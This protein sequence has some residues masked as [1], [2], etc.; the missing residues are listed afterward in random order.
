MNHRRIVGEFD[1]RKTLCLTL[2]RRVRMR[3][4]LQEEN[5]ERQN[6]LRL[7]RYIERRSRTVIHAFRAIY[8]GTRSNI[9]RHLRVFKP[10]VVTDR[11]FR[12]CTRECIFRST[13]K[14]LCKTPL[15]SGLRRLKIDLFGCQKWSI[16]DRSDTKRPFWVEPKIDRF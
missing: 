6:R 7:W 8:K 1:Q 9:N 5:W 14:G 12:H 10:D 11:P 15:T 4:I 3:R 13:K 2:I 16:I